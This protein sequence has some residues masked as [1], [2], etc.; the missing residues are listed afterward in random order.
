LYYILDTN[1][2]VDVTQGKIPCSDLAG[3]D[4]LLVV[5]APFM[6]VELMKSTVKSGERFFLKD[7]SM[8]TCIAKFDILELTKVFVFKTLWNLSDAGTSKV[9]PTH[10]KTLLQLIIGSN[11]FTDF[12]S[13]TK[14]PGGV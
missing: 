3:K 10:Y 12:I 5:V 7:Q 6:I 9:R 13:K 4:H 11:S 8:F 2:W 1:I 14:K